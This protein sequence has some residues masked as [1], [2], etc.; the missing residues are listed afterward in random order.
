MDQTL[1]DEIRDRQNYIKKL[2]KDYDSIKGHKFKPCLVAKK[3]EKLAKRHRS[4]QREDLGA[5]WKSL[6]NLQESQKK[7][8]EMR[9][10]TALFEK[11]NKELSACTFTPVTNKALSRDSSTIIERSQTWLQKKE[12]KIKEQK[13]QDLIKEKKLSPFRPQI[14]E[15]YPRTPDK[16]IKGV[17]QHIQKILEAKKRKIEEA[18]VFLLPSQKQKL[19]RERE[20]ENRQNRIIQ[21]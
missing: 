17:S 3:T 21:Q 18:E 20:R 1:K 12:I 2:Q 14:V 10:S 15:Y 9:E 8:Q 5:T 4:R 16:E 7:K 19:K 13:R 6:Y 11:L